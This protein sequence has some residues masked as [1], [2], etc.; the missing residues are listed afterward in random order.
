MEH[1]RRMVDAGVPSFLGLGLEDGHVPTFRLLPNRSTV[2]F[3]HMKHAGSQN[4]RSKLPTGSC[5]VGTAKP[6]LSLYPDEKGLIPKVRD[7]G[8]ANSSVNNSVDM[9]WHIHMLIKSLPKASLPRPTR[10]IGSLVVPSRP[11]IDP[12]GP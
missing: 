8:P 1:G 2:N 11:L 5:P 7:E 4:L 10:P 12:N 9:R 6:P 3:P